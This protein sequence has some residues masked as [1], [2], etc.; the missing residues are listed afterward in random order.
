MAY[1]LRRMLSSAQVA[2]TFQM[3]EVLSVPSRTNSFL[4]EYLVVGGGGGG[5]TA[6]NDNPERYGGGGGGGGFLTGTSFSIS[7]S[8]NYTVSIGSG[9]ARDSGGIN[10]IFSSI[11]AVGGGRGGK[12]FSEIGGIGGYG[13]HVHLI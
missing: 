13:V 11:N 4:I 5:G 9:G 10:S 7:P 6:L 12:A 3:N 1:F 2:S 8:T